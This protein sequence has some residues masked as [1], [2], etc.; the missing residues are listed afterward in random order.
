MLAPG[1]LFAACSGSGPRSGETDAHE[2]TDADADACAQF[3]R[4]LCARRFECIPH[5]FAVGHGFGDAFG[6]ENTCV[7]RTSLACASWQAL[8]GTRATAEPLLACAQELAALPCRTSTHTLTH[9]AGGCDL[10]AG[11]FAAG[12]GCEQ[13]VQCQSE[14]CRAGVCAEPSAEAPAPEPGDPCGTGGCGD[15]LVCFEDLCT[16]PALEGEPCG[17]DLPACAP[18]AELTC[19]DA[20]VCAPHPTTSGACGARAGG[21]EYRACAEGE[22]VGRNDFGLGHC[23]A[24]AED[25]E[26]CEAFAGPACLYP[27]LCVD[28]RCQVPGL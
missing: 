14:E 3:A 5:A 12:L 25:G 20:S 13:Y 27:A 4:A 6:T 15:D 28:D 2:T 10:T 18:Y 23:Q 9:S 7:E 1:L 24:Y 21:L 8:P 26:T 11:S 16:P 17:P 19:D 22:C